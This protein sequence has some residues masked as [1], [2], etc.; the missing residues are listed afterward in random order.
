MKYRMLFDPQILSAPAATESPTH[1]H[2]DYPASGYVYSDEIVLPVNVALATGRPLLVRGPSG[3]GKSTLASSVAEVLGRRCYETVVTSQTQACALM[4]DVDLL[5]RHQD[6]QLGR[7]RDRIGDYVNP[8][9]IWKA[10]DHAGA[11]RQ[12]TTSG[13]CRRLFCADP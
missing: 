4:W 3:C 12:L 10:V 11:R 8:G 13:R 5:Q 9:I 6:A 1:G 7:I 2:G